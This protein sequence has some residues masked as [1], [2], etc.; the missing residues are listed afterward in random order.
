LALFVYSLMGC[1]D[2]NVTLFIRSIPVPSTED[3]CSIET[4][5]AGTMFLIGKLDKIFSP[6]YTRVV[7]VGNQS[8]PRGDADTLR[9]E[10]SQVTIYEAEVI[11]FDVQGNELLSYTHPTAGFIDQANGSTPS[12]GLVPV[13]M[14]P[15]EVTAVFDTSAGVGYQL[16][17][18]IRLYGTTLGGLEVSTGAWD[19][20]VFL[21]ESAPSQFPN[22]CVGYY[23]P[24]DDAIVPN[25]PDG[26]D[27]AVALLTL[28]KAYRNSPEC[29][30]SPPH[31]LCPPEP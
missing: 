8:Q 21:C 29:K 11:V 23:I 2:N 4:D 3:E 15:P 31:P 19:W 22:S 6:S 28:Y 24:E 17:S 18:R 9:P 16:V 20:P 12:Y 1:T 27:N 25:C 14:L 26:Q 13:T 5:P 7:L 10:T 30:A